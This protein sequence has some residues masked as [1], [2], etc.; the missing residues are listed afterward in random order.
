MHSFD[1]MYAGTHF[2]TNRI[3]SSSQSFDW[4]F[5]ETNVATDFKYHLLKAKAGTAQNTCDECHS[6]EIEK[7]CIVLNLC[8]MERFQVSMVTRGYSP[9]SPIG[10]KVSNRPVHHLSDTLFT[11]CSCASV[12]S[13][14]V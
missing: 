3:T 1:E 4:V 12:Y 9:T 14:A 8:E 10:S 11:F 7:L 6:T 13:S 5:L 2:P